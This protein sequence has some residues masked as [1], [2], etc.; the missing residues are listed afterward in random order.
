[1]L[2]KSKFPACG[3]KLFCV[4]IGS[5]SIELYGIVQQ[6]TGD[7]VALMERAFSSQSLAS[8]LQEDATKCLQVN[9]IALLVISLLL[10]LLVG[11]DMVYSKVFPRQIFGRLFT[12]AHY[13]RH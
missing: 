5:F 13:R 10:T 12:V 9:V 6:N 11:M 8:E 7:A 2:R 1:M 3:L 4:L